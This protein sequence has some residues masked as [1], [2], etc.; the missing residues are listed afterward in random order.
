MPAWGQ[1]EAP[2]RSL[3]RPLKGLGHRGLAA[4]L[5]PKWTQGAEQALGPVARPLSLVE[6]W[7]RK[8]WVA[9]CEVE[10]LRAS[11]PSG[12]HS[13]CHHPEISGWASLMP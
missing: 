1:A 9:L 11:T 4:S 2:L 3:A 8:L 10:G 6:R 7:G 13:S 5:L 12:R